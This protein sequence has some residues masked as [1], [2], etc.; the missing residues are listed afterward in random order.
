MTAVHLFFPVEGERIELHT[1]VQRA[2]AETSDRAALSD[3]E[4]AALAHEGEDVAH[5]R[6]V[7]FCFVVQNR[8]ANATVT[9][10]LARTADFSDA[11]R[12]TEEEAT[13]GVPNLLL[14]TQYYWRVC[15][16]VAGEV[17]AV[18]DVARFVTSARPPRFINAEGLGNVRDLGG[19]ETKD[20]R[21]VRQGLLYRGCEME[22][23]IV[24]TADGV[25]TLHDTLGIRTEI[26]LRREAEGKITVSPLGEDVSYELRFLDPY[27][28]VGNTAENL[29]AIFEMLTDATRYPVYFHCW[30][31]ADRTGTLSFLLLGA[32]GVCR[33][34]L[35][36]DYELTS[37]SAIG[38][39]R[40][41]RED[42]LPFLAWLLPYG[43]G[44]DDVQT[45]CERALGDMGVSSETLD[46]LRRLL[47]E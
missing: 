34:D 28:T 46:G 5:A 2:F 44:Q 40:W 9:V 38:L 35:L 20:G 7:N 21:H 11:V 32:L 24:I 1:A 3:A 4:F 15:V 26:D 14:A 30:G 10:A 27:D 25:R 41:N 16:C 8:P 36:L 22:N 13:A 23:H 42:F 31:G 17:C 29:C 6:T 47:L 37:L 39:R 45:V 19:W 33:D 12:Y 43:W 18:S